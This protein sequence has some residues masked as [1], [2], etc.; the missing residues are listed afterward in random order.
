MIKI[1]QDFFVKIVS[2]MVA[3][4][5][6]LSSGIGVGAEELPENNEENYMNDEVVD[7]SNVSESVEITEEE[8]LTLIEDETLTDGSNPIIITGANEF[9]STSGVW[10]VENRSGAFNNSLGK[11]LLKNGGQEPERADFQ[12]YVPADGYYYVSGRAV[13]QKGTATDKSMNR[14][15]W[16]AFVK[17]GTTKFL[18]GNDPITDRDDDDFDSFIGDD[19]IN[20]YLFGARNSE[21]GSLGYYEY[22]D[23]EPV[24]L[25]KGTTTVSVFGYNY[26]RMDYLAISRS[27]QE[28]CETKEIYDVK[29]GQ[30]ETTEIQLQASVERNKVSLSINKTSGKNVESYKIYKKNDNNSSQLVAEISEKRTSFVD[31]VVQ[32]EEL[33]QYW[34]VATDVNMNVLWS[35]IIDVNISVSDLATPIVLTGSS[36]VESDGWSWDSTVSSSAGIYN[37]NNQLFTTLRTEGIEVAETYMII[38]EAGYYHVYGRTY[39]K[40]DALNERKIM[41]SVSQG[42]NVNFVSGNRSVWDDENDYNYSLVGNEN[43]YLFGSNRYENEELG[44]Y[45][46]YDA[47]PIYLEAG[48]ACLKIYGYNYA[49]LDYL[50]VCKDVYVPCTKEEYDLALLPHQL[51]LIHDEGEL[52][53][54]L[55]LKKEN[56]FETTIDAG[57]ADFLVFGINEDETKE[58]IVSSNSSTVNVLNEKIQEFSELQLIYLLSSNSYKY[59]SVD[60]TPINDYFLAVFTGASGFEMIRDEVS[61]ETVQWELIE[62]PGDAFNNSTGKYYS[63]GELLSEEHT[64]TG[65]A[66]QNSKI[67]KEIYIP[68]TGMYYVWGRAATRTGT[69]ADYGRAHTFAVRIGDNEVLGID[70]MENQYDSHFDSVVGTNGMNVY[71]FG[72]RRSEVNRLAGYLYIDAQP[73]YLQKGFVNL[74]IRGFDFAKVDFLAISDFEMNYELTRPKYDKYIASY[75]DVEVP[76]FLDVP[77]VERTGNNS[78]K[79]AFAATDNIGVSG[80]KILQV[81]TGK[82]ENVVLGEVD[83][84]VTQYE[85]TNVQ[86]DPWVSFQIEAYDFCGNHVQS[87]VVTVS[88]TN[89]IN[90]DTFIITAANRYQ[91]NDED[92][93]S[94]SGHA[95][96]REQEPVFD[97]YMSR[98]TKG[99]FNQNE[100]FMRTGQ[101]QSVPVRTQFKLYVPEAGEYYVGARA[102]SRKGGDED[103]WLNRCF[104]ITINN[105]VVSTTNPVN[106]LYESD[107]F[108]TYAIWDGSGGSSGI[109]AINGAYLFGARNNNITDLQF[110]NYKVDGKVH[111]NAGENIITLYGLSL[112]G[113]D[114]IVFSKNSLQMPESK[115]QYSLEYLSY[116]DTIAPV[117][118]DVPVVEEETETYIDLSFKTAENFSKVWKNEIFYVHKDEEYLLERVMGP[119]SA[120][121]YSKDSDVSEGEIRL[122]VYD[123]HN[124]VIVENCDNIYTNRMITPNVVMEGSCDYGGD[125]DFY[126]FIPEKDQ[127]IMIDVSGKMR[128]PQVSIYE[129]DGEIVQ[130]II[131]LNYVGQDKLYYGN[132]TYSLKQGKRYVLGVNASFKDDYKLILFEDINDIDLSVTASMNQEMIITVGQNGYSEFGLY[133]FMFNPELIEVVD[134]IATI[135]ERIIA[136]GVFENLSVEYLETGILIVKVKGSEPIIV[137]M[138]AKDDSESTIKVE[139]AFLEK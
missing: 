34:V 99:V 1:K 17:D 63:P 4:C 10:S 71:L 107:N 52:S 136:P 61:Q 25:T 96:W 54:Q 82:T 45:H 12:I 9:T 105:D 88:G 122:K 134:A 68:E 128:V 109:Y 8:E 76:V 31:Y 43:R 23:A 41:V 101:L 130:P 108:N 91:N 66:M 132:A 50:V 133:K 121:H 104:A 117:F 27:R 26:A 72:A 29:Y 3:L 19:G 78:Y 87:D 56:V 65:E 36:F 139:S 59:V 124:N 57:A 126:V 35:N 90:T 6:L 21:V 46:Y 84:T 16:V 28:K 138:K 131:N 129:D 15:F 125:T 5:I 22:T 37:S 39:N 93:A 64:A 11:P 80:Y 7:E 85:V 114:Y 33:L 102:L 44:A 81:N 62:E 89:V 111:L 135:P 30:Y 106:Y 97:P 47:E 42:E 113:M 18:S 48:P 115:Y 95:W 32:N 67:G 110:Y 120:Y 2:L 137:R 24:Y 116:E 14:T 20:R 51:N 49:R 60:N 74:E 69:N 92:V 94:N 118:I 58:Y 83:G 127:K 38:P 86:G 53:Q 75:E 98:E 73:I 40:N 79:I 123:Y 77:S 55:T 13:T 70:P 103:V 100:I 119:I 112:A